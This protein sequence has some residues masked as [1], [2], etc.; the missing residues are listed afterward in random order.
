[1]KHLVPLVRS[2]CALY[3]L[4]QPAQLCGAAPA[5][6]RARDSC[7]DARRVLG[8]KG[9]QRT[10]AQIEAPRQQLQRNCQPAR[11]HNM[12][13]RAWLSQLQYIFSL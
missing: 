7:E 4:Q 3:V 12:V 13:S 5:R 8:A 11:A 9:M 6:E 10:E 2:D 1:M